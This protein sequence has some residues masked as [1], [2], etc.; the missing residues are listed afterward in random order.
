M[1]LHS[2]Y[3]EHFRFARAH[4]R[5]LYW[6]SPKHP[7]ATIG[8]DQWNQ[9]GQRSARTEKAM[10]GKLV[11]QWLKEGKRAGATEWIPDSNNGQRNYS[12]FNHRGV[13]CHFGY[14]R[15]GIANDLSDADSSRQSDLWLAWRWPYDGLKVA[16][17][18]HDDGL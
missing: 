7:S 12:Q 6:G 15:L 3:L 8:E 14:I 1:V 2:S 5:R 4:R 17:R 16:F 13:S 11:D 10:T 9:P 18:C